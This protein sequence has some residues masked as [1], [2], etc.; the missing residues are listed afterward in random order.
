MEDI[1]TF[2]RF[3]INYVKTNRKEI[4]L[5]NAAGFAGIYLGIWIQK[6]HAEVYTSWKTPKFVLNF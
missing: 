5:Y 3:V 4:F 1:R 2:S 6:T